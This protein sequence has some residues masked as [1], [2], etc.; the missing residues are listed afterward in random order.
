MLTGH[1]SA[2]VPRL[3][4][5]SAPQALIVDPER[6]FVENLPVIDRVIAGIARR[7]GL[8][9]SDV[10]E[11]TSWVRARVIA[12][13]YAI[14]RKFAGRSSLT[15]YLT[16]VITNLYRDYR[17][18][19]WGRWRPS[20][21]AMRLGPIGIRLE[22]LLYRDGHTLR[23]AIGVLHSCSVELD[24]A[25]L[26]RLATKLP[27]REGTNEVGLEE[28]DRSESSSPLSGSV[29][30][31]ETEQAASIIRTLLHDLSADDQVLV[32]M[33]FWDDT[34]VADI[35]RTLHVD[36]KPLYRRLESI[37]K[38]LRDSLTARGIDQARAAEL[39]AGES[40]WP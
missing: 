18:N 26:T 8:G 38:A 16:V 23:E 35:A 9:Q 14:F 30:R 19:V 25:E 37:Q 29:D 11:F 4:A 32:R 40:A 24:A 27:P 36:Q 6:T 10:E 20:A 21:A 15:T 2:T 22:E 5:M 17:N 1:G 28:L 39:L 33:R 34:S 31:E 3:L 7:H 12:T 13:D